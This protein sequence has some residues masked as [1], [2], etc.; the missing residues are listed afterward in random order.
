MKSPFLPFLF[1][2][3]SLISSAI[4]VVV[5]VIAAVAAVVVI[6]VVVSTTAAIVVVIIVVVPAVAVVV[7]VV[8]VVVISATCRDSKASARARVQ[9]EYVV[10]GSRNMTGGKQHSISTAA[11]LTAANLKQQAC[12]PEQDMCMSIGT[13]HMHA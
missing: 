6:V 10:K 2:L 8:V 13:Q 9:Y 4:V 1:Q 11:N 7:V 12:A 3:L 5:I